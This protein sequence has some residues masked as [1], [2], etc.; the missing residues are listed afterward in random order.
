[1]TNEGFTVVVIGAGRMGDIRATDLAADP[2]VS[3]ILI[4]NRTPERAVALAGR[5][6]GEA[7]A[8]DTAAETTADAYVMALA[9]DAHGDMLDRLLEHGKPIL[10]EKP[11][12]LTIA[13]TQRICDQAEQA[14]V[15]MQIGFQRRFDAGMAQAREFVESGSLGTV[16]DLV[17]ASRDH[18]P[19][20]RDFLPGSGGIFR[21]LH[22]HDFDIASWIVGSPIETVQA[23]RAIRGEGDYAEFDDADVTKIIAT[24]ESGVPISITGTRHDARGHDVRLEVFGSQ[25]SLSAGITSRTPLLTL[26]GADVGID[27]DVYSG[28]IDRFREAF[29]AETTA[30][31]DVIAGAP[32]PCP[33]SA[34][35]DALRA[36]IACERAVATG[37]RILVRDVSDE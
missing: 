36:A 1:M 25:D 2:R 27:N 31:V 12:A 37:Q 28:F 34:A 32:N 11:I 35:L 3:R 6:G 17:L 22:V 18:T 7:I 19:P 21:D 15:T 24:T 4:A 29:R 16:Y 26:D 5:V 8:W 33:P 9:T 30:F 10:C 14:G 23:T 13:D 20:G